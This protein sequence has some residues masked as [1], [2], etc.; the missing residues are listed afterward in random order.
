[1]NKRRIFGVSHYV[2][3]N[4]LAISVDVKLDRSRWDYTRYTWT[5]TSEE[6]TPSF[7]A[8][9]RVDNAYRFMVRSLEWLVGACVLAMVEVGLETCSEDIEGGSHDGSSHSTAP[10][11][12]KLKKIVDS[13]TAA[14]T[15]APASR[16]THDLTAFFG[17]T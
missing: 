2:S 1:M 16:C 3:P 15:Y 5:E 4:A 7:S 17:A 14:K 11:R 6:C 12:D 9:Y 13:M 8:I 10:I